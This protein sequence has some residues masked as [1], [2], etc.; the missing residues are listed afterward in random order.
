MSL[1]SNVD[2]SLSH[3][4]RQDRDEDGFCALCY[5]TEY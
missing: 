3:L 1:P 2:I 5:L 4:N